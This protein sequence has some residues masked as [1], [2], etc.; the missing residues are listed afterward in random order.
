MC[1]THGMQCICKIL[2]AS[3]ADMYS[4]GGCGNRDSSD[5]HANAIN[6]AKKTAQRAS[7]LY[8]SIDSLALSCMLTS[9]ALHLLADCFDH[10]LAR[11]HSSLHTH[12]L[13]QV[14]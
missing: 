9:C 10:L 11:L 2:T 1:V 8:S 4:L 13:T 14:S 12:L 6:H 7:Y 5:S 3:P